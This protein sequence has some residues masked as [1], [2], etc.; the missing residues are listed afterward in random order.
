LT[1]QNV[2]QMLLFAR[3]VEAGSFAAAA[4]GLGQTRAAVSKQIARLESRIG[5]QLLNRTTRRMSLTEVGKEFYAR[6]ARI[7]QEAEEAERDV[8]SLQGAARGR[9]RISVPV[10][11]GRRYIAPLVAEFLDRYPEVQIELALS[12]Q[13]PDL[14]EAG[15]DVAIRIASLADSTLIARRLAPSHHAVCATPGY[16]A[17]HGKP[18]TPDE[19]A[20][21]NCLL[22][23][24]LETP[25]RWR[26]KDGKTVRVSGNFTV[27]HGESLRQ[28]ALDG[29]GVA[30][31]P[32][33]LVG[34][35]IATGSLEA[36][37]PEYVESRQK[38][39]AVYPRNRNLA[40][41]VRAF[42]DFLVEEF[43]PL[44]PWER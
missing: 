11:F 4:R 20:E 41:K 22:Y 6:C 1:I 36:V 2:A 38:V 42:V 15:F 7:A 14:I 9:L 19:L 39:Y 27:D 35:D 3:V 29:L 44:P 21:H 28:A 34:P 33:F 5:A 43:E 25:Q 23:S 40:P 13:V 24:N 8:A 31:M 18:A 26:F 10:T 30:Y 16:F 37:L 32:S 17:R 12:D